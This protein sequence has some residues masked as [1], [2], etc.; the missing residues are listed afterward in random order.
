MSSCEAPSPSMAC[1]GSPG[2]KWM[3]ANTSVATPIRTGIVSSNL[4]SR[5]LDINLQPLHQLRESLPGQSERGSGLA[6]VA[7]GS[8]ESRAHKALLELK[9]GHVERLQTI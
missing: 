5:Y 6:A 9:P 8:C 4:R 3:S 1:A 2:M 7:G